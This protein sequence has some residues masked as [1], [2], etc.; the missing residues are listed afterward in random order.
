MAPLARAD[1]PAAVISFPTPCS[2]YLTVIS[3]NITM[4]LGDG[5]WGGGGF[6][7]RNNGSAGGGK[8]NSAKGERAKSEVPEAA[9]HDRQI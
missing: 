3:E 2:V 1:S 5:G 9:G 7:R 8:E 6:G 4:R